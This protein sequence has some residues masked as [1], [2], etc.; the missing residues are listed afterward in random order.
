MPTVQVTWRL[1]FNAALTALL[2]ALL[3]L[4]VAD[5]VVLFMVAFAVALLVNIRSIGDQQDL[6]KRQAANAVPVMM[7][8]LGV[9]IFTGIMTDAG[10]IKAMADAALSIVPDGWGNLIPLFTALLALPLGFFMSNDAYRFGVVPVLAESAS[11][12]GISPNETPAPVP[13]ARSC[14]VWAPPR[15]PCGCCSAWSRRTSATSRERRCAGASPSPSQTS[16]SLC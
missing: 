13:S 4:E 3:I 8:V 2:M 12:Y 15:P 7:L 9:G 1:W 5:L 10:M 14:T 11:H 16:P 6:I